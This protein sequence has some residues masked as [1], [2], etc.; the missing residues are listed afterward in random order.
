M[1]I[2]QTP[3]QTTPSASNTAEQGRIRFEINSA[4]GRIPIA[5]AH[6]SIS[7]TGGSGGVLEEVDTDANGMT[8]AISLEAPPLEYSM[9]PTDN[10]PYAEYNI[11][12]TA[13]GFE[14]RFFSGVQIFSNETAI[15]FAAMRPTEG[16]GE[17]E[18]DPTVIAG[19]TLW[20]EFPPKIPEAEIKPTNE[21][22]EIVLN[23]VVVPEYIVV[24]DGAPSDS[25][26]EN[27]YIRYKDYIK[28]VASCEIYSTWPEACIEANVLAIM[29]F[30]LNRVYTE[31]YRNQGYSFTI[32]S[33]TAY[34]HKWVYGKSSY[35]S[36]DAVVDRLYTSYL[37][38]PNVKQ[39]ILTQYCDGKRVSCP[40]WMSQWGSKYLAD[41]NYTAIQIL[42]NYYGDTIYIN[43]ATAVSGVPLSWPGESLQ[44]GSSG[45]AV[46]TIQEQLNRIADNYPAIPK[47]AADGIY[48]PRTEEAVRVFQQ[49][50]KL[51]QTGIVDYRTW[52]KISE[53]YVGVTRIAELV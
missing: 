25:T 29:S 45:E 20:E 1:D 21:S 47:I 14:E 8:D 4:L 23:Q 31:W 13:P 6:I 10:Q 42:K 46:R 43:N 36:I 28:N 5:N 53:I 48:G 37:S 17:E 52:Y 34:D 27:Y 41:Q 39:P 22:G 33:S 3:S 15:Q 18:Y 19:H 35:E 49:V 38:R 40:N 32:T 44:N 16:T 50:F 26:A 9:E 51:P 12:I 11:R 30:T 7:N 2:I 24:H